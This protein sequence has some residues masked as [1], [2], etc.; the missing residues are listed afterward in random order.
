ML[1]KDYE[2]SSVYYAALGRDLF[3]LLS[4]DSSITERYPILAYFSIHRNEL[5]MTRSHACPQHPCKGYDIVPLDS[6]VIW[7]G[8]DGL[9]ENY[10]SVQN[11]GIYCNVKGF[12]RKQPVSDGIGKVIPLRI[13]NTYHAFQYVCDMSEDPAK[14]REKLYEFLEGLGI[15][16]DFPIY[17]RHKEDVA[18]N[19]VLF[20]LDSNDVDIPFK[21][22][23]TDYVL[24]DR[25]HNLE[26][27]PADKFNREYITVPE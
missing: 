17:I 23:T 21:V 2:K 10:E 15:E 19:G 4:G 22:E 26:V 7:R 20:I 14:S 8:D 12:A 18:D 1:K 13:V 11:F 3:D 24:V 25:L 16:Q 9:L 6:Y 5:L 27:I